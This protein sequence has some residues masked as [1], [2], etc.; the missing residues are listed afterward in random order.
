M[1]APPPTVPGAVLASALLAT[2][3]QSLASD[4]RASGV[5]RWF[6]SS[7]RPGGFA[8]SPRD[9]RPAQ[10]AAGRQMLSGAIILGGEILAAG[11]RGD[12]WDQPSPSRA[13]AM[14]LHGFEWLRDLLA[15]EGGEAE[16]LRL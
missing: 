15:A 3:R 2:A 11:V 12:P 4:W 5:G 16:A 8:L 13:F 1:A 7:P 14:R 9:M 10:P 6:A